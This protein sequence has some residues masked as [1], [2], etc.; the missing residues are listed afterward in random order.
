[1]TEQRPHEQGG[2]ATLDG[3]A[4]VQLAPIRGVDLR[5]TV[6]KELFRKHP[7]RF[8]AKFLFAVALIAA[9][10][11]G[12]W[13]GIDA[14]GVPGW[15]TVAGSVVV[16]GV[17]YAH[18]VELQHECLHEH[19][20]ASRRLN[21]FVGFLCGLAMMSSF[22]HYKYEHLRHHAYLGTPQNKEFFNYR[23]HGLDSVPGF[24]VAA[25]HPGRY[26]DVFTNMARSLLNRPI[27]GVE[28]PRDLHRIQAEYRWFA[29]ALVAGIAF[30][31]ATGNLILVFVWLLPA[32][33]VAEAVHFLIEL[34]EHFGLNTQTDPNVLTNTRTVLA[35]PFAVWVTNG[36]NLHTAHHYHQGVP[37][38]NVPRLHELAKQRFESV[39]PSYWSFYRAVLRGELRYQGEDATCMTR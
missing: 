6:P 21:R 8:T 28:R 19:A 33:L 39:M 25:M 10:V 3:S 34:P 11:V 32:L 7:G 24:T 27:R 14:G 31:A 13:W 4:D 23:F 1:M 9:G 35:G 29:L 18:L 5:R 30:T 20:Y 22:A 37:M 38:T 15:L 2:V 12:A 17:M 16:L 36:N 26:K